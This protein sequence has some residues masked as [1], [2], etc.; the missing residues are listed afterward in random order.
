[1]TMDNH[2][3]DRVVAW[4]GDLGRDLPHEEQLHWRSYNI[5]PTCAPS[6]TFIRRQLLAQFAKSE[7]PEHLFPQCYEKLKEVCEKILGWQLLLPLTAEDAHH[8]QAIRIP[9]TDEQKDFDDLV[10]SLTK[11]LIDSLNEKA[12]NLYIPPEQTGTIKGSISRLEAA[13]RAQGVSGFEPH[14]HFLRNL[15][16]LR[17]SGAAHRKGSDYRKIADEF[18]VNSQNLRT[19]FDGILRRAL[20]VLNFLISAVENEAFKQKDP[21]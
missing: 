16:S 20:D 13:L 5:P 21:D 6:E 18:Q 3:D 14:I 4:L 2:H 12:L 11:I 8:F 10:Q 17:S 9:S 19:V 1:M 15:Q 7:R